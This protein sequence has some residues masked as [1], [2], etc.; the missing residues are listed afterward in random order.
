M[1][2]FLSDLHLGSLAFENRLVHQNKAV[3]LLNEMSRDASAIYLL[4]D[5]F[6]F[7]LLS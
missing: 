4:G 3:K 6:D 5:V 2:Y 1:I 7:F